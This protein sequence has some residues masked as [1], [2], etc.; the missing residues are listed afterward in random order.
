[1]CWL[2]QLA[3]QWTNRGE[4]GMALNDVSIQL[5]CGLPKAIGDTNSAEVGPFGDGQY[6]VDLLAFGSGFQ[7]SGEDWIPQVAAST[8]RRT[9]NDIIG[10]DV[11]DVKETINIVVSSATPASVN[12]KMKKLYLF[13]GLVESFWVGASIEPVYLEWK[14]AG[15]PG[16]QYALIRSFQAADN[17]SAAEGSLTG[18][19]AISL[20]REPYWRAL[21]PG[22]NPKLWTFEAA[23]LQ[24][25]IDYDYTN[26]KLYRGSDHLLYDTIQ[27]RHEWNPSDYLSTLSQ[28]YVDIPAVSIPGDAPA[29]LC[30]DV[31]GEDIVGDGDFSTYMWLSTVPTSLPTR[32]SP[33]VGGGYTSMLNAGDASLGGTNNA[34]G[35][36]SNGSSVDT[37]ILSMSAASYA[38]Q[39]DNGEGHGVID[40]S[41]LRGTY[42][43]LLRHR[44]TTGVVGDVKFTF[45]ITN[46][47]DGVAVTQPAFMG[48]PQNTP[49]VPDKWAVQ[50]LASF[51]IPLSDKIEIAPQG[52]GTLVS[53]TTRDDL[54]IQVVVDN[55]LARTVE[56]LDLV[57]IKID[58]GALYGSGGFGSIQ[59]GLTNH[60]IFDNTGYL[61][62]GR[63]GGIAV[64][65]AETTSS[66]DLAG[67]T[68]P[69]EMRGG[70][71]PLLQPN[72]NN[73]L[74]FMTVEEVG[75]GAARGSD[76]AMEY[77][78]RVNIIPRWAGRRDV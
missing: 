31:E 78:I 77:T 54:K 51:S 32:D 15:S 66:G 11:P 12:A 9:G 56:Y 1:M 40:S 34:D 22:A 14:A 29:L 39:W 57:L 4:Q 16:P 19:I 18:D 49:A 44:Q 75:I 59:T 61:S 76:N 48:E 69:V 7:I 13:Q 27:N 63:S 24:P 6:I 35:N 68:L 43:A 70:D 58:E 5:V 72:K 74:N 60:M 8:P 64:R 28:N 45:Q 47:I 30:V 38:I 20:E 41:L 62:H 73:R 3:K 46:S 67:N 37:K 55:P 50:Y 2:W 53:P 17:T 36:I 65:Y 21:P 23:G 71:V 25:G 52:Y 26:L 33:S 10:Y 42:A